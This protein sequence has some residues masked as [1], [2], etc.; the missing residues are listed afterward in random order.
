MSKIECFNCG[1][2]GHISRHCKKKRNQ[3][4]YM[5]REE[6]N[7]D[8]LSFA[9]T[10]IQT[11]QS[12]WV[13]DSGT[14]NHM[15][16]EE[17]LFSDLDRSV[18]T[19]IKVASGEVIISAGKGSIMVETELGQI[20]IRDVL[21]V[22][23]IDR[24]LLS[25]G[26]LVKGGYKVLFDEDKGILMDNKYNKIIEVPMEE[27]SFP[28][29][30]STVE[31]NYSANKETLSGT[32]NNTVTNTDTEQ[33]SLPERSATTSQETINERKT[34]QEPRKFQNT[35]NQEGEKHNMKIHKENEGVLKKRELEE[36]H[37]SFRRLWF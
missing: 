22:P 33:E 29:N 9:V 6:V 23:K 2:V 36:K 13:L 28:L 7:M 30:W 34:P 24:N 35:V 19:P 10:H 3:Q 18:C 16:K 37:H 17:K 31:K 26:Q 8:E 5:H 20:I 14:T 12:A 21:L 32:T 15:V 1:E 27:T 11:D 4:A 25:V